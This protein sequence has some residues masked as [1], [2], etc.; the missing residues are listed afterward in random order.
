MAGGSVEGFVQAQPLAS[1]SPCRPA[2]ICAALKTTKLHGCYVVNFDN[3]ANGGTPL[4]LDVTQS[5]SSG[6]ETYV[7]WINNYYKDVQIYGYATAKYYC[8]K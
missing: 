2:H 1:E 4:A 7:Y 6:S 3:G 5:G 8:P